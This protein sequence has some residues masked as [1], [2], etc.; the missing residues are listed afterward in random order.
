MDMLAR[1]HHHSPDEGDVARPNVDRKPE[2]TDQATSSI[3]GGFG[4]TWFS[5]GGGRIKAA[6]IPAIKSLNRFNFKVIASL[7]RP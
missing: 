2:K 7:N 3:G 4:L 1:Q 5:S 6:K